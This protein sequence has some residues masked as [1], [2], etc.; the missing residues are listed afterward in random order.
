MS[1]E[2]KFKCDLEKRCYEGAQDF[3]ERELSELTEREVDRE[4]GENRRWSRSVG[5]IIK[6]HDKYFSI[7][8]EEGLTEYQENIYD[9]QPVEVERVEETKTITVV[10]WP[11]KKK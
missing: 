8:Y 6:I 10:N 2:I 1:R 4:E 11:I 9:N 3:T 7:D 5:V